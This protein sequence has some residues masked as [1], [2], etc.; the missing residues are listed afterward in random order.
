MRRQS[1]RIRRREAAHS[2]RSSWSWKPEILLDVRCA[3]KN[4]PQS[5]CVA[6]AL[7]EVRILGLR[8]ADRAFPLIIHTTR[9]ANALARGAVLLDHLPVHNL[10]E[11]AYWSA[12]T[13]SPFPAQRELA[14]ELNARATDRSIPLHKHVR[15][16]YTECKHEVYS[17]ITRCALGVL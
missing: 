5:R 4:A 1:A 6:G 10:R 12:L 17:S 2:A 15:C 8:R 13:E 16:E 3:Q 9:V 7:L 14:N 11:R